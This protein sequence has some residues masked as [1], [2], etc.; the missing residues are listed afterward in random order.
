VIKIGIGAGVKEHAPWSQIEI[1]FKL[2]L[3]IIIGCIALETA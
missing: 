3:L 1:L 2:L